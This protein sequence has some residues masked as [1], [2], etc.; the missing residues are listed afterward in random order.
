MHDVFQSN[1]RLFCRHSNFKLR[2]RKNKV[3]KSFLANMNMSKNTSEY[4]EAVISI[5]HYL[6][7]SYEKLNF[8]SSLSFK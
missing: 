4:L 2:H 3:I 7:R 8:F 1:S 5:P 6:Y